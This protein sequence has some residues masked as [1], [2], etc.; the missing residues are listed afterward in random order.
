ML[1]VLVG[2][3]VFAVAVTARIWWA[4]LPVLRGGR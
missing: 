2:F 1:A 4:T 3:G